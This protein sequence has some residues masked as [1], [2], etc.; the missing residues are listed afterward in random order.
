MVTRTA[1]DMGRVLAYY[2]VG[3][4]RRADEHHLFLLGGGL[5]FSL[6]V[7]I[8]PFVLILFFAVGT[9]LQAAS[10]K[11][12]LEFL[13]DTVI[14]YKSQA[15]F[16]KQT[17]FSRTAGI[18]WRK[19]VFG[20]IGLFGL[21]FTASGLFSSMRT[22]LNTV[23]RT[24]AARLPFWGRLRDF[25]MVFLV[26]FSFLAAITLLPILEVLKDSAQVAVAFVEV[27]D[28]S[29][30]Q[31]L[32]YSATTQVFVLGVFF[33]LYALVPY[34]KQGRAVV[35]VSALWASV[36]WEVAKQIFGYYINNF[37][38]I[39]RI[40][41]AYVLMVVVVFWIY[42]SSIVFILGAE[43]GQLSRERRAGSG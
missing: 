4:Y 32:L 25:G 30:L 43:I 9:F 3:L 18:A 14:P 8:V 23:Y 31:K 22:I 33:V 28:P 35:F 11:E 1:R 5:A 27:Y 34:G 10:I 16:V 19:G 21:L 20:A 26:L 7:C 42:Y 41:G 2:F 15:S 36:L 39:Q 40:Y 37:A 12:P 38:S 24:T 17:L 29:A 6:L 13:V